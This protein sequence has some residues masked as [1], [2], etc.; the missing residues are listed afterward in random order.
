MSK[1]K[2]HEHLCNYIKL[3]LKNNIAQLPSGDV[4]SPFLYLELRKYDL[5]EFFLD[6]L[7]K[8]PCLIEEDEFNHW[9]ECTLRAQEKYGMKEREPS[10][11]KSAFVLTSQ[12]IECS[13]L[14]FGAVGVLAI[15][16][17]HEEEEVDLEFLIASGS[18]D[19]KVVIEYLN[20]LLQC[21]FIEPH[22]NNSKAFIISS[23]LTA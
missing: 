3:I 9:I 16:L 21:G 18:D 22:P 20:E 17:H 5:V 6:E 23:S 1:I 4:F 8:N 2:S 19:H 7:Q 14:S 15:I 10:F 11:T 12:F 13:N